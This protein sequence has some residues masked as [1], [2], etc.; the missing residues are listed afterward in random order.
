MKNQEKY[1]YNTM[2][3]KDLWELS[4]LGMEFAIILVG[5][6]FLGRYIDQNFGY[7]PFGMLACSFIGFFIGIYHI[8]ARA[9]DKINK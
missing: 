6:V 4:A 9:K 5:S 1:K 7:S 8:I 2:S 3:A